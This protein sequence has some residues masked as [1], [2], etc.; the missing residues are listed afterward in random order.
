MDTANLLEIL[1][2]LVP[3]HFL[4][5]AS[6]ANVGKNISFLSASASKVVIHNSFV[7]GENLADITAKA[8]SQSIL[9]STLGMLLGVMLTPI[10]GSD[11]YNVASCFAILSACQQLFCYKSLKSVSIKSLNRQ[12]MHILIDHFVLSALDD[13]RAG[14][15]LK[16]K[17][18]LLTHEQ[19]SE[20]E[21]IFPSVSF[22]QGNNWLIIGCQLIDIA[23]N[24]DDFC[25]IRSIVGSNEKYILS[26]NHSK[27][28]MVNLA[29][30]E[31]ATGLDIIRGVLHA[32]FLYHSVNKNMS[33]CHLDYDFISKSKRI[34][35]TY[36]PVLVNEMLAKGWET[37]CKYI[38]IEESKT[39]R[40]RVEKQQ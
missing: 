1:S 20:R 24:A 36:F 3:Q 7:K 19:V 14:T 38:K 13:M 26:C 32:Y 40:L 9:A 16:T 12:R 27:G 31:N 4:A 35:D 34:M 18:F 5:V 10:V 21:L 29:F 28:P 17:P 23:S 2:P 8:G 11:W 25:K 15:F 30:L 6:I 33:V 37:D 39:Y 22:E